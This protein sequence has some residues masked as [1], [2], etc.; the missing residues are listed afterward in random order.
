MPRLELTDDGHAALSPLLKHTI[1]T[2]RFPL[3]LRLESPKGRDREVGSAA[4]SGTVAAAEE[5]CAAARNGYEKTT[6]LR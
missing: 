1:D 5:P 4:G 6:R 3:Q 2:D